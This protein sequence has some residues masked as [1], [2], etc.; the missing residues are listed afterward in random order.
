MYLVLPDDEPEEP[1]YV[2][3]DDDDKCQLSASTFCWTHIIV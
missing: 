3:Y 2:D 1:K